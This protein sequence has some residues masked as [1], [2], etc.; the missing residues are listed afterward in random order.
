MTRLAERLERMA[1]ADEAE[2]HPLT[3]ARK[4]HRA[5]I[6]H[7]R[8]E[9]FLAHTDAREI[10]SYRRGIDAYRRAREPAHAPVQSVDVPWQ[11]GA[12]PC[13]FVKAPL[14][15]PA[16]RILHPPGFDSLKAFHHPTIS[17]EF[18]RHGKHMPLPTTPA[19]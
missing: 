3:A 1:R 16:P 19:P 5:G 11:G 6:Y 12:M 17:T 15:G 8:A 14:Q 4:W 18:R 9:R 13:I 2:G 7:L 10:M